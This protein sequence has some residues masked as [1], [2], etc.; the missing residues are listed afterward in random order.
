MTTESHRPED[1]KWQ[2]SSPKTLLETPVGEILSSEL[3][4]SRT[5]IRKPFYRFNFPR[6]VNIVA[7]TPERQ[8]IFIEQYRFGTGRTELEIPGGAVEEDESVTEAGLRELLEE[9]G[10]GGKEA[11]VIGKVIPNPALQ[12][13]FCY[14]VLVENAQ[15]KAIPNQDEMEDIRTI[16]FS[17]NEL[18]DLIHQGRISHGLVLNGLM[19]YLLSRQ[20]PRLYRAL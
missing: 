4:C 17:E 10:Y 11:K 13:N 2:V 5:G 12:D 15:R 18:L 6:W 16:L 3:V 14:T 7:C 20:H 8:I 19:F 9:T 1:S